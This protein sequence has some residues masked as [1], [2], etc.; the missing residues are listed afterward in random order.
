MNKISKV[1]AIGPADYVMSLMNAD[2]INNRFE[3]G[4]DFSL[5]LGFTVGNKLCKRH[6]EEYVTEGLAVDLEKLEIE[7]EMKHGKRPHF[8]GSRKCGPVMYA[9]RDD[10]SEVEKLSRYFNMLYFLQLRSRAL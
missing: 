6:H 7:A 4:V 9:I 5:D 3:T 10:E 1:Y 8:E 2:I